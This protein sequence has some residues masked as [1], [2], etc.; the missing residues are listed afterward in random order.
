MNDA[1]QVTQSLDYFAMP[2]PGIG[3][4]NG[5]STS[6][7]LGVKG[8]NY[9]ETDTYYDPLGRV[10][11]TVDPTGTWQFSFYD[12]LGQVTS[13]WQG[14]SLGS[15]TPAGFSAWVPAQ[16][17][18]PTVGPS[19]T[20]M[21]ETSASSYDADG[22]L[23]ESDSYFDPDFAT[24][25]N[26]TGVGAPYRATYYQYDWQDRQTGTLGPDGVAT[27]DQYYNAEGEV[28][29]GIDNL[30]E[31]TGTQTFANTTLSVFDTGDYQAANLRAQTESDYDSQGRV[32]ESRTY[33]VA[34]ATSTN[35]SPGTVGDY[36][37][38]DTWYD[39]NGNVVA[40]R[41]GDGPIQK[42]VY[43]TDGELVGSYTCADATPDLSYSGMTNLQGASAYYPDT[44][45]EQTQTWYDADGNVI[46]TADYQRLPGD[47]TTE[48]ALNA[49]DSYVTA[50]TTFYDAAGR[51]I[52][53]VNYG[54]QD[55]IDA[56]SP[57]AFFNLD[58]SLIAEDGNPAVAEGAPPARQTGATCTFQVT[59]TIYDPGLG[60]VMPVPGGI[61]D[62]PLAGTV[63]TIDNGGQI[64]LTES[65]LAG[66][67]VRTI[68]DYTGPA[69]FVS[70]G[71]AL[72]ADTFCDLTT[73]YQYDFSGRMVG[74]TVYDAKGQGNGVEPQTTV[75]LYESNIDGSLQTNTIEPDSTDWA[76]P[77]S[78]SLTLSQG[79]A[80]G[81]TTGAQSY[82]PGDWV[83]IQGASDPGYDGWFQ[84]TSV[85]SSTSFTYNA[86]SATASSAT[87]ATAQAMVGWNNATS[88]TWSDQLATVAV[89]NNYAPGDWVSVQGA[90]Q[91]E[92]D[93]WFQVVSANSTSFTY[94]LSSATT[95]NATGTIRVRLM[96]DQTQTTYN[97]DGSTAT[98]TDQRGVT[99]SYS[100]N[101]AGQL[102]ADTITNFGSTGL[103]DTTVNAIVTAYDDMGRVYTVSSEGLVLVGTEETETV[104]NQVQYQYDGWGDL[105]QEWQS[106]NG[107][108][109]TTGSNVSPSVQYQYADGATDGVAS[110]V[111][112]TDL[113]YPNGRHEQYG[114]GT[115]GAVDDIM[116][117]F[118]SISDLS[119]GLAA[120]TYLGAGTVA[121]VSYPQPGL[122][123]DY[124]ADNFSAWDQ[125]GEVLNQA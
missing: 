71:L 84:V 72:E 48:G 6:R 55:V 125:F 64:T 68:Q 100:Y 73:D 43:N 9:L 10:F 2:A 23:I 113:I 99:H 32:Y 92:F 119:G 53:D 83:L 114:Y 34:P 118:D 26:P 5:Y 85:P 7:N 62:G 121:S 77:E 8:V 18:P 49:T 109:Q 58:G 51:D 30:G 13:Q 105:A 74:M 59:T 107:A 98:S 97:L 122:S 112:L 33:N 65:D 12:Y 38:T 80:T 40:T 110:Y 94:A 41:T 86:P 50:T 61:T 123:L 46:A 117:R 89:T 81:T 60:N 29:S 78:V 66:R 24:L 36:L 16:T 67:T 35:P 101:A 19:G 54:R 27:I 76:A 96:S 52:E 75:Y 79:V 116:S 37:P 63:E 20:A 88:L 17:S 70:N 93:G 39:A 14:T 56:S 90:D 4:P 11:A 120:Y 108:V 21:Y 87:G 45:V 15:Y 25:S 1:G 95:A 91:C 28:V 104:L 111:R 115:A 102:A 69:A 47:T 124:S 82:L 106:P 57:T 42:S 31:V 103:V 22:N 44:V 3:S